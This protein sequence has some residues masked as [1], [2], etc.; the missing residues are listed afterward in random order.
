MGRVAY[1]RPLPF[2]SGVGMG[3]QECLM[4]GRVMVTYVFK[5][6]LEEEEDGRWSSWIDVLPGCAAWGY[7]RDEALQDGTELFVD[8]M[9]EDGDSVPV[10][11][12]E[13]SDGP[14]VTVTVETVAV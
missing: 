1:T 12:W 2:Q 13:S 10:G 8:C 6:E 11:D 9:L 7:T 5:G 4:K 14:T 3:F